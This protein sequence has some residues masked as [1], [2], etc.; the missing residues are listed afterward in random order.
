MT[1]YLDLPQI[2][3]TQQSKY[4][5]ANEQA[6]ALDAAL[7]EILTVTVTTTSPATELDAEDT[8]RAQV[9][10]LVEGSPTPGGA[11]SV[12]FPAQKRGVMVIDNQ[13][14]QTANVSI[15]GQSEPAV[16][17]GAGGR[18]FVLVTDTDVIA[19]AQTGSS[20]T[21]LTTA[22]LSTLPPAAAGLTV[23]L[24]DIKREAFSDGTSWFIKDANGEVIMYGG[25][26]SPRQI[27]LTDYG[28]L[29]YSTAAAATDH[30]IPLDA[31]VPDMPERMTVFF[32][33]GG[34][35]ALNITWQ[36][37]V[38]VIFDEINFVP[39]VR[40]VGDMVAVVRIA[41]NTWLLTGPLE[42]V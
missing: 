25:S 30:E 27:A 19:L 17:V 18:A 33:R 41:A 14:T 35:G 40:S 1:N 3:P 39:S 21:Q 5:T 8:T 15:A 36:S 16:S 13:M 24:T 2:T 32:L 6:G 20:A 38:D 7:A 34:T 23:F 9:I 11:V 12:L 10:R 22:T 31:T 28:N 26:P 37:G 42:A 29:I 4:A